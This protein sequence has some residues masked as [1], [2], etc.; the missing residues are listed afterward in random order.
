MPDANVV[1]DLLVGAAHD[2]AD[3][4]STVLGAKTATFRVGSA[5]C[6]GAFLP[7]AMLGAV[8]KPCLCV[9]GTF[10]ISAHPI[11]SMLFTSAPGFS[12]GSAA[13]PVA[14]SCFAA[15]VRGTPPFLNDSVVASFNRTPPKGTVLGAVPSLV[16][17]DNG[18]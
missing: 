5:S 2:L 13:F 7:A 10:S 12:K 18:A 1:P 8:G 11:R 15:A 17:G 9:G 14:H 6:Y 3:R 4:S 16:D